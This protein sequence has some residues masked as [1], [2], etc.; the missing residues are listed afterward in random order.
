MNSQHEQQSIIPKLFRIKKP[1]CFINQD[2]FFYFYI[3]FLGDVN[4]LF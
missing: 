3:Q 4:F 2:G 1:S